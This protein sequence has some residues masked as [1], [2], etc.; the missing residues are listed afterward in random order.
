MKSLAECWS[1]SLFGVGLGGEDVCVACKETF[2]LS[3]LVSFAFVIV[4]ER[5][6]KVTSADVDSEGNS[7]SLSTSASELITAGKLSS[8]SMTPSRSSASMLPTSSY[9]KRDMKKNS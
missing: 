8:S 3:I 7:S 9:R 2:S 5:D 4:F 6:G 1:K